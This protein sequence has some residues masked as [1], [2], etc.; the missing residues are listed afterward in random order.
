MGGKKS[1][2]RGGFWML[3]RHVIEDP[4]DQGRPREVF[5]VPADSAWERILFG[6]VLFLPSIRLFSPLGTGN[7]YRLSNMVLIGRQR[8]E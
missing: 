8:R 7:N 2:D 1:S 4:S 3:A 6:R 5:V